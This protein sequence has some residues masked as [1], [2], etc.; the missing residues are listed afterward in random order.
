VFLPLW[1]ITFLSC[2]TS[3]YSFSCP[4]PPMSYLPFL[5]P[6]LS[7]AFSLLS[8]AFILSKFSQLP[9]LL[10]FFPLFSLFFPILCL[11]GPSFVRASSSPYSFSLHPLLTFIFLVLFCHSSFSPVMNKHWSLFWQYT[12]PLFYLLY[13]ASFFFNA[14]TDAT[15]P[16]SANFFLDPHPFICI[17]SVLKKS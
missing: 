6:L 14:D 3:V 7:I 15:V 5:V 9:L 8:S 11:P 13:Q 12:V 1:S 2:A 17:L 16:D 10:I 4:L